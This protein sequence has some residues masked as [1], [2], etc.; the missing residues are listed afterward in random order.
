MTRWWRGKWLSPGGR[1]ALWRTAR[2][3]DVKECLD[4]GHTHFD[5]CSEVGQLKL[6][7]VSVPLL[8]HRSVPGRQDGKR[9]KWAMEMV[10][11]RAGVA[12]SWL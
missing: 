11:T 5:S 2:L 7:E 6:A 10:K 9:G 1:G 3:A 4:A 8:G 12:G